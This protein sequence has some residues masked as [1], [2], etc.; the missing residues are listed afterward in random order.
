MRTAPGTAPVTKGGRA[1]GA[2][3]RDRAGGRAGQGGGTVGRTGPA[4]LEGEPPGP[5]S[6]TGGVEIK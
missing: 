6:P 4:D 2:A 3:R 1:P 5:G